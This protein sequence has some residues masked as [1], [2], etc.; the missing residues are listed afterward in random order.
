MVSLQ[1]IADKAKVS[2]S[3]VSKILNNKEVRVSK[4]TR[5]RVLE[6]AKKYNYTPN[7]I[8]TSLRTNKTNMIGCVLPG[9]NSD[10]FAELAYSI[11]STAYQRGYQ[12]ILCNTKEDV[13]LEKKYLE[14][15][16]SGMMDGMIINPSDNV[17]N[18]STYIAM[19]QEKFPYIFVD[20]YIG[21]LGA[22]FVVSDG[23]YGGYVLTD[24]LIKRGHRNILFINHGKSFNTSVQIERYYGYE[25]AMQKSNLIPQRVFI[26]EN[27][28]L[29]KQVA[30]EMFLSKN[31]PTGVVMVSSW[32]INFVL[33]ICKRFS[34]KIPYDI[35]LATFDR[36]SVSYS[37]QESIEMA[38]LMLSPPII[39]EQSPMQMGE[40]A[41]EMILG[42]INKNNDCEENLFI[43]P[44]I[45]NL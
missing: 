16:R 9:I 6:I 12:T 20:R 40:R 34:F 44:R 2:K 38:K 35:E 15:F 24:E 33:K 1:F 31:R 21:N 42:K 5:N 22:G 18:L 10:F 4:A 13:N 19:K 36:F 32:D 30:Y 25:Q 45:I 28:P 23:Y 29:E 37:N 41:V 7:R 43:R 3:L 8:A 17:A 11:E 26:D 39:A 14:L 27:L